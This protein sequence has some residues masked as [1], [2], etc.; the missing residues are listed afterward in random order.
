M[1]KCRLLPNFYHQ[2][3]D[4]YSTDIP[5]FTDGSK[6][7]NKAALAVIFLSK[8]YSQK[9]SHHTSIYLSIQQNYS[10]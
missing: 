5:I 8:S 3:K 6:E 7:D 2:N 4:T 9:L 1:P 10:S